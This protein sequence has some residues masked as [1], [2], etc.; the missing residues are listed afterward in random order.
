[1]TSP[2]L[3]IGT[4]L[5][6]ERDSELKQNYCLVVVPNDVNKNLELPSSQTAVPESRGQWQ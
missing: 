3:D 2:L 5:D 4:V 6:E 1:M